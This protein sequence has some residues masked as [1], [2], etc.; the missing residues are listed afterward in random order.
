MEIIGKSFKRNNTNTI[1][2]AIDIDNGFVIFDN[3]ARCKL[4]TLMTEF[5]KIESVSESTK[6][7]D[8]IDPDTF[9]NT[10]LSED[11]V[12]KLNEN[13]KTT[14]SIQDTPSVSVDT[15]TGDRQ[16]IYNKSYEENTPINNVQNQQFK[17]NNDA[18]RSFIEGPSDNIVVENKTRNDN[19]YP[20]NNSPV[21]TNINIDPP[22]WSVYKNVKL[23]DTI[24]I[25]VP[26]V[27]KLPKAQKMDVLNDMFESSFVE[28]LANK[29]LNNITNDKENILNLIKESIENWMDLQLYG[30]VKKK[31]NTKSALKSKAKSIVKPVI[32]KKEEKQ[33]FSTIPDKIQNDADLD[34]IRKYLSKL[35]SEETSKE[36]EMTILA[37]EEKIAIYLTSKEKEKSK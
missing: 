16:I 33:D 36:I 15:T 34:K 37:L 7:N 25:N 35:E 23:T 31:K 30:K 19:F 27:I 1:H 20:A 26:L 29:E 4:D 8:F 13:I 3:N 24:T 18:I 21:N 9:F 17:N 2:K 10:P 14:R 5:E 12:S 28:Y 11:M 32:T 6:T 22:E